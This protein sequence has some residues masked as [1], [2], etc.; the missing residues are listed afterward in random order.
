M[1]PHAANNRHND[2]KPAATEF[3]NGQFCVIPA[4]ETFFFS[5]SQMIE[6]LSVAQP[7]LVFTAEKGFSAMMSPLWLLYLCYCQH[8][9]LDMTLVTRY[10][11]FVF[12]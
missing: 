1:Q 7:F 6:F 2:T 12:F 11:N 9:N 10:D 8:V 4:V 5:L 3:G